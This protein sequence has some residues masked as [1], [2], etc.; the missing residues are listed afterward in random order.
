MDYVKKQNP[1]LSEIMTATS[2]YMDVESWY[3]KWEGGNEGGSFTKVE[4]ITMMYAAV[5]RIQSDNV[6]RS[7]ACGK[8]LG[9]P[10][11]RQNWGGHG[12][13]GARFDEPDMKDCWEVDPD[14]LKKHYALGPAIS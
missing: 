3:K 4:H 6:S 2:E 14:D 8:K 11:D 7:R 9:N 13:Q 1:I 10:E 12:Y 5:K